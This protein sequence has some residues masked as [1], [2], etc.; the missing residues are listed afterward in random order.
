ML[1]SSC[2]NYTV[3]SQAVTAIKLTTDPYDQF[4]C[5][6]CTIQYPEAVVLHWPA[7]R[8]NTWCDQLRSTLR[9]EG[10]AFGAAAYPSPIP[11]DSCIFQN[12]IGLDPEIGGADPLDDD[13]NLRAP[14]TRPP[15]SG[16]YAV[17]QNGFV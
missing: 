1:F 8:T 16:A 11:I 9:G 12:A 5:G 14:Y 15:K 4:C 17:A 6:H 2:V 3:I 10:Y 7:K 13:G